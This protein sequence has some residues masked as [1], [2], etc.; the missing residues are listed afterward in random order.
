MKLTR[1]D[2]GINKADE[3]PSQPTVVPGSILKRQQDEQKHEE[4]G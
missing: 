4:D 1:P 3:Q 2:L